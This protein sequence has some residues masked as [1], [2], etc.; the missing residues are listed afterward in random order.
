M[1]YFY[2]PPYGF[3][4]KQNIPM[5]KINTNNDVIYRPSSKYKLQFLT[6]DYSP[7]ISVWVCM[8]QNEHRLCGN[9]F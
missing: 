7:A 5:I 8:Q 9:K 4:N 3:N 1:F 6:C 2:Y